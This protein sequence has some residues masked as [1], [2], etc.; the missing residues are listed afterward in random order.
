MG[1]KNVI[2]CDKSKVSRLPPALY[3]LSLSGS[4]GFI[5]WWLCGYKLH[6]TLYSL[7]WAYANATLVFAVA[8]DYNIMHVSKPARFNLCTGRTPRHRFLT[9]AL[10]WKF[11]I[12][13]VINLLPCWEPAATL[14]FSPSPLDYVHTQDQSLTDGPRYYQCTTLM[15]VVLLWNHWRAENVLSSSIC[16]LHLRF[17]QLLNYRK[18]PWLFSISNLNIIML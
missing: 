17:P 10:C 7:G 2:L 8:Y 4:L 13:Q 15:A 5:S 11:R 16:L 3:D 14:M 6:P 18:Y 1:K 12:P 9:G